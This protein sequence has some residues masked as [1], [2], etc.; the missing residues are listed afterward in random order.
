MTADQKRK[1]DELARKL[2][3]PPVYGACV[4]CGGLG[5]Y[6]DHLSIYEY[7]HHKITWRDWLNFSLPE[8]HLLLE[9]TLLERGCEYGYKPFPSQHTRAWVRDLDNYYQEA[10]HGDPAIALVLAAH[11][12]LVGD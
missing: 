3:L 9:K 5:V 8:G 6:P 12:L 10:S 4:D 1:N 2:G 7:S 11:K